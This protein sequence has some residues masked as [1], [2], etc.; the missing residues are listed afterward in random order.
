M[1]R[2]KWRLRRRCCLRVYWERV[3]V[4]GNEWKWFIMRRWLSASLKAS[5]ASFHKFKA[6][7]EIFFFQEWKKKS[8]PGPWLWWR[9][10]RTRVMS[11]FTRLASSHASLPLK[12]TTRS[13]RNHSLASWIPT[14]CN[15]EFLHIAT[16]ENP[17][18]CSPG[19]SYTL[20]AWKIPLIVILEN[21]NLDLLIQPKFPIQAHDFTIAWKPGNRPRGI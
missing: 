8:F 13:D 5:F 15:P 12:H 21:C 17:T 6:H 1:W 14:H 4:G 9:L 3:C 20:Q 11:N 18:H 7:S 16:L 2:R 19:K 10:M